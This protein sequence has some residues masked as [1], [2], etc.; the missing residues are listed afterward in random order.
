MGA[1][2]RQNPNIHGVI[3]RDKEKKSAQYADD[4]WVSLQFEER[5]FQTFLRPL[6]NFEEFSGLNISYNKSSILRIGSLRHSNAKY[7]SQQQLFWSDGPIKVLGI[8]VCST[9]AETIQLNYDKLMPKLENIIK[10]WNLRLLTP[11]GKILVWNSLVS[12]QLVYKLSSLPSP[13]PKFFDKIRTMS[14]QFIWEGKPSK[15]KYTKLIQDY[16]MGGLRLANLEWRNDSLKTVWVKRIQTSN[17]FWAAITK[18]QLP[19]Q[20]ILWDC[21]FQAIEVTQITGNI[22]WIDILKS[23]AKAHFST[24]LSK[25]QILTQIIWYNHFITIDKR[26][27]CYHDWIQTRIFRIEQLRNIEQDRFFDICRI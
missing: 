24:P 22:I 5:S 13:E 26:M 25:E 21:N 15:V 11:I 3:Y 19:T 8:D 9:L 17:A 1:K 6:H 12:S 23:W 27:L 7:Y 4:L 10:S 2:I 14:T 16:K 18:D 20:L